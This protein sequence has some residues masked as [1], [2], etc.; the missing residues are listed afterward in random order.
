MVRRALF[1]IAALALAC[2]PDASN[3]VFLREAGD[4][5]PVGGCKPDAGAIDAGPVVIPNEPLENWDTTDA[6]PLS[7]IFAVETTISAR[8]V[9][10]VVLHQLLRLRIVQRGTRIHEK[11]TLCAFKLPVVD[12]V[13]TLQIPPKLQDLLASKATEVDGDF[14]SN[15]NVVGAAYVPT[16]FLS[17]AGAKLSNEANDPLPT[18]TDPST[19]ID[20]DQD[21]NP[22]VTL[23]AKVL[24]CTDTEQ[25]YVALRTTGALS[26]TVQTPDVIT[27]KVDVHLDQSIVGWSNDCLATAAKIQIL[28]VP[29]SPFRAQRVGNAEDIDH[30][31][32]VSC[33]ELVANAPNIFPGWTQ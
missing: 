22:G 16:P 13:A 8:V 24:T 4:H 20:E 5:C 9:V 19:A 18:Q 10:P 23:L 6:G 32:N 21:G 25:L 11:T 2:G 3:V 12:N 14:L 17:L 28:I 31:G 30:N 26:G 15:A 33:P 27:G 29:G 1:G 7:G